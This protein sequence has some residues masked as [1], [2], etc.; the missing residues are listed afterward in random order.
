MSGCSRSEAAAYRGSTP[1]CSVHDTTAPPRTAADALS[2]CPS[3][4]DD[5]WINS[6]SLSGFESA[7]ATRP[8]TTARPPTTAAADD[9]NPRECGISLRQRTLRPLAV[10]P[11]ACRPCSM[12]RTT[13]CV[14]SSGTWPAPSPS[15]SIVR[16]E[17]VV[18]TTIS[19]YRLSARPRL[20]KP[21]PRLALEAATTAVAVSPAGRVFTS[22]D[23]AQLLDDGGGIDGHRRD[24]RHALER[25]VG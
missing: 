6:D 16:P 19:S 23:Q 20:S 14:A 7:C 2:G 24:S 10:T 8:L 18:S 15:T 4:S 13:K 12:A 22:S 5:S 11:A 25:G 3:N 17:S 21:G 9:P 1:S